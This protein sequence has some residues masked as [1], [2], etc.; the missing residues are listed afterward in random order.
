MTNEL[1]KKTILLI[2]DDDDIVQTI[3]ANLLVDG[4]SVITASSG[5]AG[6]TL[7][8]QT[9]PHLVLLDLNLPDL[10]GVAVC[11]VLRK[12]FD[13]PIIMLTAR[14]TLSDKVLGFKSGADDY[15][16]KPFDFLELSA[17]ITAL[18]N[19]VD[20]IAIQ[21][22]QSFND[23]EINFRTRQVTIKNKLIKLTKTE[24][25][26]LVLLTSHNDKA[27]SREFIEKQIW[28]DS[29]LYSNSRALDVH[30]QRLR[31]KIEHTPDSPEYIVTI[32]GV[33]YKFNVTNSL[34]V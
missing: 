15:I 29:E 1:T 24:F 23:L 16:I 7:A 2:D 34:H 3:K 8:K 20:R 28:K 14:D 10:D 31:K 11:E 4:Y 25:E 19:R 21:Y 6:I 13:F 17:R 5:Q 22:E 32:P 18:F 12:E 9:P 33:G 27:L 30:I 26:L